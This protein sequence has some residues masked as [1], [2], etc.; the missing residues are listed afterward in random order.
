M[1]RRVVITGL[2]PIAPVGIGKEAFWRSLIE[3]RSGITEISSFDASEFPS[4]IAG[5]VCDFDPA[6]FIEP[7]EIKRMDRFCHFAVAATKLA[8]E[9]AALGIEPSMAERVGV[10]V[11]VGIGGL[12]TLEEQ[13]K[14]LLEKGPRRVSPFLVPMM[15]SDLAAG[16]VSIFTGARGP[17][18][19]TVT[20]CASSTHAIG[21]AYE[22][23]K[24]GAADICLTG[25]TE[26][27]IT[28]LG[29]AGFCA[30]RALSTRNDEPTKASRPFD[31]KRDGFVIA[32]GAG[33]VVLETLENA[34]ARD[35]HVY[36]EIIGYGA[37]GDAHHI[38]AP[39]PDGEGAARAVQM[40]LDEAG[41]PATAVDYINAHGTSTPYNDEFETAAIKKVFGKHAYELAISSTKSMTGHL[42]GA[43]G[44]IELIACAMAIQ[45]GI[46]PPTINLEYPDPL[47]DLN[48]IPNVA[49]KR[50]VSVAL[51][52]SFGF[53]GHN[54]TLLIRKLT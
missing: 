40:A 3:G 8:L 7:R 20:A 29:V 35:A 15:I 37:T 54:A 45:T 24:R 50:E 13:H 42:L 46:I 25:G 5:E 28:P 47:C 30:A 34:L 32:E 52:N 33:I 9:D 27:A 53:G 18:L 44:A 1:Q 10:I 6:D 36:A 43:T 49:I 12:K 4:R 14:V 41:L 2:G 48:Y 31:A 17:N 39:A 16:Y 38:T 11:G 22:T 21:E 19:C 51:S 26:A 23:I